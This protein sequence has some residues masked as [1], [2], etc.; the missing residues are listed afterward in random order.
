ML[1][2]MTVRH[3][4]GRRLVPVVVMAAGAVIALVG[5]FLP[6]VRTGSRDRNSYDVFRVVERLGFAPD[7]PAATAMRWWPV[8]PLLAVG[9]VV[10][11]W[12][13][14][15]RWGGALGIIA[16]VYGGAVGIAVATAPDVALLDIGAGTIVTAIGAGI[17]LAGSVAV[18]V[19]KS[20]TGP[21]ARARP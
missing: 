17:L 3:P 14:W 8:V 4:L 16:A 10:A 5:S 9:A 6:W 13:G 21:G 1:D 7:G 2:A 12:W 20:P 19:V 15:P 11:A 18:V